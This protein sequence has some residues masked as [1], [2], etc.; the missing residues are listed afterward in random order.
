MSKVLVAGL[1]PAWQKILEFKEFRTGEV[2][3]ADTTA[4]LAS[5]KGMNSAKVLRRLG[6]D[7]HLLQILGGTNGRRCLAACQDLGI[8][9]VHAWIEEE[10]RLC[11]TLVDLGR[12]SST[13]IIE[14]F[15]TAAPDLG[16]ILLDSLP[17]EPSAFD[18]VLLSGTI[19]SGVPAGMF[20]L[21]LERFRPKVALLD[22]WKGVG[23][24][25]LE[26]AGAVKV[27]RKE[28]E[29]L[30]P[31]AM[32]GRARPLFLVTDG[33]GDASVI[34]DGRILSRISP[35]PLEKALNPIGAG[36]TV[37]A[38]VLHYLL[39]GLGPAE[40]FR[41]GLAMGTASCLRL[42][43][44]DFRWEDFEALLPRVGPAREGG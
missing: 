26:K 15:Q 44:A 9:S 35:A 3:R 24:S 30:A 29:A 18:A 16:R 39:Q 23:A 21:L 32:A 22:A 25:L 1:N 4:E 40:A 17:P 28:Y 14:P 38:G 2:N 12:E 33:A 6:H 10:T 13:E 41:R 7:V 27:N 5:G 42:E 43:P 8:R 31:I 34:R 11:V 19:P 37:S 20:D 36:D